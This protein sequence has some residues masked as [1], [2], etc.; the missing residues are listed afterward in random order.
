M[1][2]ILI[3]GGGIAG[4]TLAYWLHRDGHMPV[5]V[6]RGSG[7]VSGGYGIDFG[8]TGYDVAT[9]MGIADQLVARQLPVEAAQFVDENGEV[10]ASLHRDLVDRI[11]RSPHLG[12][13]HGAL[14]DVL[15]GAIAPDVEFHYGATITAIEQ[16]S[17]DVSVTLSDGTQQNFDLVVGADGV[18]SRVRELVFGP[19]SGFAHHLGYQV[20]IHHVGD[21]F[22]LGAVRTHFTE[23]GRQL[24]LYPTGSPGELIA[25]YLFRSDITTSVDP[26]SRAPLLR[27]VFGGMGWRTPEVLQ[28][29]PESI[30]MDT[31]TQIDMA[32][33]Y[34]GRV[35][36]IGD[37]C[38]CTTL[39]S[40][41][42]VSMALAGGYLLAEALRTHPGSLESAFAQYQS[43]L[44]PQI[45]R[46][47][48]NARR[49]AHGLV[50]RTRLGLRA[51]KTIMRVVTRNSFSAV[52]RR[53][54]GADTI[55]AGA[56]S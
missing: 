19:E 44:H 14:E 31:L 10:Y 43:R 38:G 28:Q 51:Q 55:L 37:A 8:G 40:T 33:W 45:S 29:L 12:L 16:T 35:V 26:P 39:A 6:E 52:L 36:L 4:M 49:F 23:P 9:R 1:M 53:Q 54:F 22:G 32:H 17:R 47:Q 20:A 11:S 34:R 24:V 46:R 18:H 2:R 41:Q 21:R 50:P 13:M 7:A 3:S 42:G 48:R 25:M 30:F 56:R 27:E 15:A 5:I